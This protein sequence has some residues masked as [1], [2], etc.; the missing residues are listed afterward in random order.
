ME[1]NKHSHALETAQTIWRSLFVSRTQFE[2]LSWGVSELTA[3]YYDDMPALELKVNGMIHKGYVTVC[4]DEG[5]D[6]FIVH[7]LDDSHNRIETVGDVHFDELG[8]VLDEKIERPADVDD[9]T[10]RSRTFVELINA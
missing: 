1:K 5:A 3:L 6:V 9:S 2:I 4:L 7:L 10:Y 8:R